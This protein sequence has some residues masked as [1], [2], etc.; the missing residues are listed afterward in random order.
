MAYEVDVLEA[1]DIFRIPVSG[2]F[3][4]A[5]TNLT[6]PKCRYFHHGLLW[7]PSSDRTDWI[8]IETTTNTGL[9]IGLLS[10]YLQSENAEVSILRANIPDDLRHQ[11]PWE[12]IP[13]AQ[14]RYGYFQFAR[15]LL[16]GT[17][18]WGHILATEHCFRKLRSSDFPDM[19]DSD[20]P[21]CTRAVEIAFLAVGAPIIDPRYPA[22]PSAF[23]QAIIEGILSE[24]LVIGTIKR[25]TR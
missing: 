23:E 15:L 16:G 6:A 22:L 17:K 1:G 8:V 9:T 5:S 2:V 13:Y 19:L 21:V 3:G 20:S 7:M 10:N 4:W 25:A 24:I 18:A 12:L 11:A 14:S